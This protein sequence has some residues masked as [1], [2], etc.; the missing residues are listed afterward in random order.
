MPELY[1][2]K[3]FVGTDANKLHAVVTYR[4]VSGTQKTITI[5]GK[6]GETE[7]SCL[8]SYNS[9]RWIVRLTGVS[10]VDGD[11][12]LSCKIYVSEDDVLEESEVMA[13]GGDTIN[14]F[15][16]RQAIVIR[17]NPTTYPWETYKLYEM[18]LRYALSAKN[19]FTK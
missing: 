17:E 15:L 7:E 5:H 10:A 4:T 12:L 9:E 6:D 19:Y 14:G 11:Q 13:S 3:S 18:T 2:L 16:S 8:F 1:F